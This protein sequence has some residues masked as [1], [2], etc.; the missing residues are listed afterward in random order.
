LDPG[1]AEF[2]GLLGLFLVDANEAGLHF[3]AAL[4]DR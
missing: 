3:C 1:R 4:P 2:A